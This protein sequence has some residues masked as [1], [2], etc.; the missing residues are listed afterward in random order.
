MDGLLS[1]EVNSPGTSITLRVLYEFCKRRLIKKDQS[2]QKF[3]RS[4]KQLPASFS[5][6]QVLTVS[7]VFFFLHLFNLGLVHSC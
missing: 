5:L 6:D 1:W 3:C 4:F 7:L 2:F